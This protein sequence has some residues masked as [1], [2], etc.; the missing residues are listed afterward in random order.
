MIDAFLIHCEKELNLAPRTIKDY[1]ATF[2]KLGPIIELKT[3]RAFADAVVALTEKRGWADPTRYKH[4]SNASVYFSFCVREGSIKA[5][6]N[7]LQNG[8]QF[9]KNTKHRTEFFDWDDPQFKKLFM[10]PHISIRIKCVLH[11]LKSSG[12]RSSELCHL[13]I[14]NVQGRWIEIESGKGGD[15]RTAPIDEETRYWLGH[16]IECLKAHYDGE[17]LFPREDYSGPMTESNLGKILTRMG[18][19]A[20]IKIYPHK[21][22]HSLAGHLIDKGCDISI[23]AAVLGH[24]DIRTTQIYTH[25]AR[26]RM[27]ELHAQHHPRG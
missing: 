9:P 24:K 26:E 8:H 13:K 3:Y 19:K 6:D 5:E 15:P 7:P 10:N 21:F 4:I 20:G 23:A 2:R 16:Y 12:I 22:R 14:K 27:K 17:W 11:V 1:R 25:V 18:K